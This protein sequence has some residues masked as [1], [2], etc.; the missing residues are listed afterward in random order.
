MTLLKYELDSAGERLEVASTSADDMGL[1]LIQGLDINSQKIDVVI[2]LNGTSFV[3][4]PEILT[5]LDRA[6]PLQFR[7]RGDI[8]IQG[9]DKGDVYCK[10]GGEGQIITH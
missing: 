8:R 1:F 3:R 10:I 6:L 9:V 5:R 7:V 2:S 4:L